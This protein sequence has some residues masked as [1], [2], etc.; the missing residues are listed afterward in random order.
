MRLLLATK[1]FLC[2]SLNHFISTVVHDLFPFGHKV[3]ADGPRLFSAFLLNLLLRMR[4]N[5]QSCTSCL[6]VEFKIKS[7]APGWV[8]NLRFGQ[9]GQFWVL[10]VARSNTVMFA[11]SK[12]WIMTPLHC[13]LNWDFFW[14][15]LSYAEMKLCLFECLAYLYHCGYKQFSR[16]I[17]E[18]SPK[19]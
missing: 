19:Y 16:F 13:V 4:R 17:W 1:P 5:G 11:V 18:N 8:R 2:T 7:S 6:N 3:L 12:A 9:F 14:H 10:H 15:W